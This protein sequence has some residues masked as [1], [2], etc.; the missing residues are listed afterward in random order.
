VKYLKTSSLPSMM[1][2]VHF[3]PA[4]A[5]PTRLCPKTGLALRTV[6]C[7]VVCEGGGGSPLLLAGAVNC[8]LLDE[9]GSQ[10]MSRST[11]AGVLA[12]WRRHV[13]QLFQVD[14]RKY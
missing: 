2:V 9:L 7:D 13:K 3:K 10:S 5:A 11:A 6:D 12:G 8:V 14:K 4:R 1:R